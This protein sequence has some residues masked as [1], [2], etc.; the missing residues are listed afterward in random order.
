MKRMW[1]IKAFIKL[2]KIWK[3]I[4]KYFLSNDCRLLTVRFDCSLL[5]FMF[6]VE[7]VCSQINVVP[8]RTSDFIDFNLKIYDL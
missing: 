6:M 7:S 3:Y 5:L 4:R 1:I 8:N 2:F